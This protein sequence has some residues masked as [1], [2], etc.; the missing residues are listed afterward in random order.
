MG[1]P[2]RGGTLRFGAVGGAS[3]DTLEAQNPLTITDL[4][5]VP[6]MF[7]SLL[8]QT[9]DGATEMRLATE[10][11][12]S[13]DG[14]E[15]TIRVRDGVTFHDGKKFG[16]ED[17]LYSLRRIIRNKLPG[18]F[19]IGPVDLSAS[20]VVNPTTVSLVY[21]EPYAIL[22]E[23]LSIPYF[24]MVP[25]GYDPK[26]PNGTGPFKLEKFEAGVASS[27]VRN[28]NYW[29][30]GL[31]YLDRIVTTN[32]EDETTQLNGLRAG[33][34]NAAN[35]I[36][37]ASVGAAQSAGLKVIVSKTG[38]FTPFTMR[39]DIA[40]FNDVR[41]RQAFRLM[42]QR[43]QMNE[44]VWSGKGQIGNDIINIAD[45]DYLKMP[46]REQDIEKAKSLLKAA[47]R[48]GMSIDLVT[49]PTV[50]GEVSTAQVFG[51][52]AK[53]AGVKVNVVQKSVTD[54][55]AKYYLKNQFSQDWYYY[56][57]YRAIVSQNWATKDAPY[58]EAHWDDHEYQRIYAE[59]VLTLDDAKRREL[60]QA[61]MR[62]EYDRGVYIIPYFIPVIDA[63]SQTVQGV[64]PTASGQSLSNYDFSRVWLSGA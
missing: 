44:Q 7:D 16:A 11:T 19:V 14:K 10:I 17:V 12:P 42:V 25:V 6:Q 32:V 9:P 28:E 51:T 53:D 33:Q 2:R 45:R 61:M 30:P 35:G 50:G 21:K 46:Q 27:V 23:A 3:T 58:N 64:V 20:K 15:W 43:E 36:S 39:S 55:F 5:R 24:A 34:F 37:A 63:V 1:K 8:A 22:L 48:E 40:P 59:S 18:S 62:I 54:Y 57:P 31:P 49:A 26:K 4:A 52:Q 38:S 60:N 13:A 56:A 29:R 41:V 47:G